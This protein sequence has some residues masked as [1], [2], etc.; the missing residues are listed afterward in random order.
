MSTDPMSTDPIVGGHPIR[1]IANDDLHR[2]RLTVFIRL[3]LV[4]SH[5]IV[6]YLWGILTMFAV[7]FAWIVGIF[8]GRVPNGLH[9]FM[10]SYVRYQTRVTA[11]ARILANPF[12]PFGGGGTYPVDVEIA[13]AEKQSRLT[14]FFRLLLAI[15][16][17]ILAYVFLLGLEIVAFFGWIVGII[18][19]RMPAGLENLGVFCL[20]WETQTRAYAMLLTGRYPSLEGIS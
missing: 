20:R 7:L 12:P 10:A 19:A 18:T 9:N 1:L 17:L 2:S 11:Y 6:L 13:P 14:I 5:V 3:L 15:P 8:V 4:I 16:A